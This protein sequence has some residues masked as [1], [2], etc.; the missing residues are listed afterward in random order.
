M[1]VLC[2][3]AN[4]DA[5]A[6]LRVDAE[7]RAIDVSRQLSRFRDRMT[8]R[9]LQ[10]ATIHDLRRA[11]LDTSYQVVHLG[12]HGSRRALS[13]ETESN[14][15]SPVPAVALADLFREVAD[16]QAEMGSPLECVVLN[17]CESLTLGEQIARNLKYTVAMAGPIDDKAAIEFARGFYDA[18]FAA[19][20]IPRAFEEGRGTV[21]LT[22]GLAGF[23]PKLLT[24][25]TDSRETVDQIVE[26]TASATAGASTL[27]V[28]IESVQQGVQHEIQCP[29]TMSVRW[30]ARRAQRL[31]DLHEFADVG[32]VDALPVKWVLVDRSVEDAWLDLPRSEQLQLYAFVRTPNAVRAAPDDGARLQDVA[33]YDGIVLHL[34][35]TEERSRESAS[36]SAGGRGFRLDRRGWTRAAE[37]E[38]PED[39]DDYEF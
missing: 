33:M 30:L 23:N 38:L 24:G 15:R 4:P 9:F 1:N 18:L 8:V 13:F 25:P 14:E 17:V 16:R 5:E 34:Y 11:L 32:M 29:K 39:R 7:Q 21:K 2:A 22:E 26:D 20:P 6:L 31:L 37:Y 19:F 27:R 36:G 10:A 12:S 35:P 28:V 3:F